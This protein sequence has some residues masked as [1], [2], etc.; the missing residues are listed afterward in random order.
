MGRL[1]WSQLRFRTARLIAL[2]VGMLLATTAFTVL[3]AAVAHVAAAHGRHRVRALRPRLR[4]PGPAQG[5]QDRAGDQDRH[6]AAELPVRHLRRHHHGPVPPDRPDPRRPGRRPDRDGRLQPARL[7]ATSASRCPRPPMPGPAASSTGSARPGSATAAPAG[8][9]SRPPTSTSR[10]NRLQFDQPHRGRSAEVLP[11]H[12]KR[13]RLPVPLLATAP[14]DPFGVAAQSRCDA[15]PRS[16]ATA[17]APAGHRVEPGFRRRLGASGAD[18]RRRSGGRGEAG[19]AQPRGDL[20]PLPGRE[21][22]RTAGTRRR[23]ATFPVLA[24]SAQRHGR[25]RGDAAAAAGAPP[26]RRRA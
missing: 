23:R 17:R 18:R 4:H 21:R 19:R 16:T 26:R 15:G 22:A 25:V 12:G 20:R 8:S 6:R 14:D 3:T 1:A 13:D 9:R 24:S 10:R 2:L 7:P 11:G 5:R